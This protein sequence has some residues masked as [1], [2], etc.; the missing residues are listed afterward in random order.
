MLQKILFGSGI[1]TTFPYQADVFL[2]THPGFATP[3]VQLHFIPAFEKTANLNFPN[4][5]RRDK[6]EANHG[7]SIRARPV[8]P[9]S[10]DAIKLASADP[11]R[12][13]KVSPNDLAD[14]FDIR[15]TTTAI[16]K[17]RDIVAQA[18][19]APYR[20]TELDRGTELAPT[21][22]VD[23]D[24]VLENSLRATAMTTLHPVGTCKMGITGEPMAVCDASLRRQLSGPRQGAGNRDADVCGPHRL[25]PD[26]CRG[27]R[28]R[29]HR[30]RPGR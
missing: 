11:A 13:P 19:L 14:P 18:A 3:D 15:T 22:A 21:A 12:P 30:H 17:T 8:H 25:H 2:R 6:V 20:G 1:V 26:R 5:F 10:R 4:P 24:A 28:F 16:R 27:D 7:C 9:A 23:S 29:H